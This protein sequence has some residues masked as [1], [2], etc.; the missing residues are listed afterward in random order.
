MPYI[1]KEVFINHYKEMSFYLI[2]LI[3]Q[4]FNVS[5]NMTFDLIL[6][7]IFSDFRLSDL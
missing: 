2:D 1:I 7:E 5:L 6:I 4:K 3:I